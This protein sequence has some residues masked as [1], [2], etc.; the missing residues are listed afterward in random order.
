M[1]DINKSS[2][3]QIAYEDDD[4]AAVIK[5]YGMI[6]NNADTSRHEYTL[7]D[8][9][10]ENLSIKK[11]K[12]DDASDFFLRDGMV[13]R[14]DKETSGVLLVAKN[15]KVFVSL[16]KQ[17]KEREVE[18]VYVALVHGQFPERANITAPVGRL[19]WNRMRFGIVPDGRSAVTDFKLEKLYIDPDDPKSK[20]SLVKAFPKTG[21]THQI[22][23]HL[24]YAGF[25]IYSDALYAGRKVSSRDRKRLGRHFLHAKEITFLHPESHETMHIISKLTD[26]L[27]GFLKILEKAED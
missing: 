11:D 8:W 14:L 1:I 2:E 7:Q 20:L 16:Q 9:V 5:P 23:V 12:S 19:P 13:H 25:P 27:S 22:R 24:Q 10:K 26:D 21:R 17:F 4:M 6:V 15:E 18:K 3:V